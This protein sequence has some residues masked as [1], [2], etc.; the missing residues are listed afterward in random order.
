MRIHLTPLA[1]GIGLVVSA[2]GS[3]NPAPAPTPT[4][5]SITINSPNTNIFLGA[6]EQMAA[7]ANLSNGTSQTPTGTWGSDNAAVAT[8]NATGLVTTVASGRATIFFESNGLRGTKAIR[9]LPNYGGRWDG[10]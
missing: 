5:Q 4:V 9:V 6:V 2:C 8:V 1:V 10:N 7:S 3:S